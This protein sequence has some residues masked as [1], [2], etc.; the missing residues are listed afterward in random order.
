M[1]RLLLRDTLH[2]SLAFM[3]SASTQLRHNE[4]ESNQK[5][6]SRCVVHDVHDDGGLN[7]GIPSDLF[8]CV[9]VHDRK[10]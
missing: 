2:T 7:E 4:A 5:I 9:H 1:W 8:E 6:S 3:L 10:T